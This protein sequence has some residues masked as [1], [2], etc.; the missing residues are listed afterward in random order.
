MS[1]RALLRQADVTRILKAAK[2]AGI[3][4]EI[5]LTR[6]EVRFMPADP[7]NRQAGAPPE[8]QGTI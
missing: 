6:N 4:Y 7:K 8:F 5:I 2:A 3:E 1:E